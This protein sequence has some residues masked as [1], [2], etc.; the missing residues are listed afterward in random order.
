MSNLSMILWLLAAVL[1]VMYI[2]RRRG[3]LRSDD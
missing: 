1:L 3:R 2:M